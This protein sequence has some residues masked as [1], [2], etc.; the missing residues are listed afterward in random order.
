MSP[1]NDP[2]IG[3]QKI[4]VWAQVSDLKPVLQTMAFSVGSI[5]SGAG[6]HINS[7]MSFSYNYNN[8]LSYTS[9]RVYVLK[10]TAHKHRVTFYKFG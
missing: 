9:L 4:L 5:I 1:S 3:Q 8:R 6:P 2:A 10:D 7:A